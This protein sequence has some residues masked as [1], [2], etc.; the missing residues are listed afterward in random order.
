MEYSDRKLPDFITSGNFF[1][2][3]YLGFWGFVI[4]RQRQAP[5][6]CPRATACV[7]PASRLVSAPLPPFSGEFEV[8]YLSGCIRGDAERSSLVR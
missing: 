6:A 8:F 7:S 5:L 2:P 3:E 1:G 4:F